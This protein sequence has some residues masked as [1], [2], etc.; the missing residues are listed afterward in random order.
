MSGSFLLDEDMADYGYE[1][2]FWSLFTVRWM[3]Y[4]IATTSTDSN[5]LTYYPND[6]EY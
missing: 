3:Y 2:D 5:I 4:P 6:I 1:L